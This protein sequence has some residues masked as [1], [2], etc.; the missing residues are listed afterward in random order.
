MSYLYSPQDGVL[1]V[2]SSAVS[3][4]FFFDLLVGFR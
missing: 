2:G 3:S 1:M 4:F